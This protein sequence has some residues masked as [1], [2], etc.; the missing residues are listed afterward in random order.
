MNIA[1]DEKLNSI[2]DLLIKL[3]ANYYTHKEG[4]NDVELKKT[5]LELFEV[6]TNHAKKMEELRITG[7]IEA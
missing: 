4:V 6:E 3:H 1:T 7:R 2:L 5:L